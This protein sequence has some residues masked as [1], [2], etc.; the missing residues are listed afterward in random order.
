MQA[1]MKSIEIIDKDKNILNNKINIIS[2]ISQN[3][4]AATQEVNAKIQLQTSENETLYDLSQ[5]LSEGA[6]SLTT[7]VNK[8][9]L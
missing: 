6:E 8:F 4:T 2:E 3:N 9:K 5:N 7:L 1:T